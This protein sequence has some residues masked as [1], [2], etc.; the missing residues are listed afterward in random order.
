MRDAA[1]LEQLREPLGLLD[2]D[3]ADEDWLPLLVQLQD[4]LDHRL[5]LLLLGAEDEVRVVLPDHLPV[6]RDDDD[7][8]AVDLRELVRLGLGRARHAGQLLVHAEVVLQR[9]RGQGLVLGLDLDA[10]LGLD[11]LVQP[12]GPAPPRHQPARELVDDDDLAVLDDV[13]AVELVQ[14]VGAQRL[15]DGVQALDLG[16]VVEVGD[17]E[18]P[19]RLGDALLGE[20]RGAG[21]LV[22]DVVAGRRLVAVLVADLLALDELGDDA[23][24]LVVEPGRELRGARDDE[25]R[26]RLVD[27][28]RVHLVDDGV[29]VAVLDHV[30]DVELHV[31]AQVVEAEL[32]VG[33]VGDVGA[34]GRQTLGVAHLVLDAPHGQ[35]QEPVDL[36]HPLGVALGQVVVD[37]DHVHAAAGEGVQ[38]HRQRGDQGL[39]LA[40]PHL[41]DLARVQHHAADELDV[42]VAH[43]EGAPRCLAH[44]REHLHEVLVEDRLH[45]RAP[46]DVLLRQ[47]GRAHLVLDARQPRPQL[48]VGQGLQLRLQR[49]D[50]RHHGL[51]ALDLALVLGPHE[52]LD[53]LVCNARHTHLRSATLPPRAAPRQ[54]CPRPTR[55]KATG[56]SLKDH[57]PSDRSSVDL[58]SDLVVD[59]DVDVVV[60][61]DGN[62]RGHGE[63]PQAG[64]HRL[65]CKRASS[66]KFRAAPRGRVEGRER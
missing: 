28:D 66:P 43:P 3:R 45:V 6:G 50:R 46:R 52:E 21:L 27:Q 7:V 23:I 62:P 51:Q 9:D 19:L 17:R 38:H 40:R 5:P 14:G 58:V 31:V 12:V 55:L 24:D 36:P 10:F 60:V 53:D 25:R 54:P 34:V 65:M 15:L 8:E 13:L 4:L 41:G 63:C 1:P 56:S 33:A 49:V 59:V 11:R 20:R 39:A 35:A 44:Q 61:V 32:V 48:V 29:G 42:E 18:E 22:D 2:R 57:H 16:R 30:G 47:L 64:S 37:G 26:P